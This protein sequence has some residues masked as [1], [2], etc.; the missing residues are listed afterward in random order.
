VGLKGT[1]QKLER[2][3]RSYPTTRYIDF[4]RAQGLVTDA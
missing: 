4:L 3:L 2:L 1:A